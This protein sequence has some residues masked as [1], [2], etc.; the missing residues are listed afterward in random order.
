MIRNGW[1]N[2]IQ[3]Y[4]GEDVS[5]YQVFEVSMDLT[6]K[7]LRNYERVVS[8][9]FAYIHLLV[10]KGIPDYIVD[11]VRCGA[12]EPFRVFRRPDLAVL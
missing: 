12:G 1:A 7:G 6:P 3:A 4:A 10:E 5:D 11:E 9:V 2:D 8:V